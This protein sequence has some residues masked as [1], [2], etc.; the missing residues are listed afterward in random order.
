[1]QIRVDKTSIKNYKGELKG[2]IGSLSVSNT[3][4][5]NRAPY[6]LGVDV[7]LGQAARRAAKSLVV[8]KHLKQKGSSV[9]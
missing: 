6:V 7:H 4:Y 5:Y 2:R 1:M 9:P 8:S 3:F